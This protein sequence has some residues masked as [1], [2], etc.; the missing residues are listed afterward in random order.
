MI[1]MRKEA[2]TFEKLNNFYFIFTEML[3]RKF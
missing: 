3:M 2:T 1:K